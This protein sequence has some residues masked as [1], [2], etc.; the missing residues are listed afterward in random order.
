MVLREAAGWQLAQ[1]S[2][3][4]WQL[5]A[6]WPWLDRAALGIAPTPAQTVHTLGPVRLLR[7]APPVPAQHATPLLLIPSLINRYYI[8]DLQPTR[9]LVAFW[10]AQGYDVW[11]VD[12]HAG[13]VD[14]HLTLDAAVTD[15]LPRLVRRVRRQ[16]GA[17]RISLLGYSIGGVLATLYAALW[18]HTVANLIN[19]TGPVRY[20]D[21]G[22]FSVWTRPA[23]FDPDLVVGAYGN[24]PGWLLQAS[25]DSLVPG[26]PLIRAR[27]LWERLDDDAALHAYLAVLYWLNDRV[28]FPAALYRQMIKMLYQEDRLLQARLTL[29]GRRVDLRAIEAPVLA[30]AADDDAIAP[31]SQVLPLV[32]AVGSADATTLVVDHPGGHIFLVVGDAA[33]AQLWQPLDRWLAPR[34]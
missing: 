18:P 6:R 22:L 30:V 33:P 29:A 8:F 31:A 24:I 19:L 11:L 21:D 27:R 20:N 12:W 10:L 14:R 13:P 5:Q 25:F 9:S 23:H 2:V 26:K 17:P 32:A 1:R 4:W 34:S 3:R 15:Y 28:D 16:T 7:Y